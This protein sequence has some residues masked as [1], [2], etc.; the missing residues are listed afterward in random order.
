M[1]KLHVNTDELIDYTIRL[2]KLPR[3]AFPSAVRNTLNQAAFED[4]K[5]IPITAKENFI[6]RSKTFFRVFTAVNKA[7]GFEVN[8]MKAATGLRVSAGS[9]IVKGLE[10]QEF[11]GSVNRGKLIAHDDARVGKS[12]KKLVRKQNYKEKIDFFD[13]TPIYRAAKGKTKQSSGEQCTL[14]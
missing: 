2:R 13:A 12:N 8:R 14:P 11:G 9:E 6:T 7:Q 1:T 10:K 5:Q 4:K 3:A